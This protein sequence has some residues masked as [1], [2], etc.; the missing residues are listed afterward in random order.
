M[1][2]VKDVM[3]SPVKS[4]GANQT[5]PEVISMFKTNNISGAPVV[6]DKGFAIGL[7]SR[8]DLFSQ[9]DLSEQTVRERMT[10]FVFE[11]SPEDEL[12]NVARSMVDAKVHRIVVVEDNKPVGIVTSLDLV[13][14]YV[15]QMAK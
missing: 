6:N 14:D 9:G 3:S 1:R 13:R 5:I 4:V 8:S 10:P 15:A 11:I 2:K 7:I 12:L